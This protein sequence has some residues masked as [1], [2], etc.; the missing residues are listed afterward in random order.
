MSCSK[1]QKQLPHQ[2]CTQSKLISKHRKGRKMRSMLN[3]CPSVCGSRRSSIFNP[4]S[5]GFPVWL[6]L[7]E[8]AASSC[9]ELQ[10]NSPCLDWK[11]TP[12]A[13][14]VM[15]DLPGIQKEQVRVEVE[16]DRVLIIS[17]EWNVE[18]PEEEETWWHRRE[19]RRG[20]FRRQLGLPE[21]GKTEEV[22]ASMEKGV[23]RVFIPKEE[24]NKK[25]EVKKVE[26]D[27]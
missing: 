8:S 15:V 23:L 12:E 4:F 17:G 3:E 20:K 14:V 16:D 6:P 2:F 18:K 9:S 5:S 10:V 26:I 22:K 19:R 25:D 11:E 27:G 24:V 21:N 1:V 13:H 7:K